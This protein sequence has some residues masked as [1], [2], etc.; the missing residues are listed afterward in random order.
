MKFLT[1]LQPR[2]LVVYEFYSRERLIFISPHGLIWL[3]KKGF[4]HLLIDFNLPEVEP[5]FLEGLIRYLRE[6]SSFSPFALKA[7]T[8]NSPPDGLFYDRSAVM[9]MS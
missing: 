4:R 7:H 6:C 2:R 8:F 5:F 3:L 1:V 9:M